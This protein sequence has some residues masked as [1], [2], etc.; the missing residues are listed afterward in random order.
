MLKVVKR[1]EVLEVINNRI[2]IRSKR[3]ERGEEMSKETDLKCWDKERI[4]RRIKDYGPI[5]KKQGDSC[6][7]SNRSSY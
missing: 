2:T 1:K 7:S 3:R 5:S 6:E 4:T